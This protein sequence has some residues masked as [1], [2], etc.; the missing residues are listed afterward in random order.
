MQRETVA[1]RTYQRQMQA[2]NQ[3]STVTSNNKTATIVRAL[4]LVLYVK[5][6]LKVCQS[7][8]GIIR[9]LQSAEEPDEITHPNHV[10]ENLWYLLKEFCLL[11]Y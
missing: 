9:K 11:R 4:I 1:V 3:P 10:E 8:P 2:T 7:G 6:M 5:R